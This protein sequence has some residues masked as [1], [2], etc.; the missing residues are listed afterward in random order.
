[1]TKEL[2]FQRNILPHLE[3]VINWKKIVFLEEETVSELT[4]IGLIKERE[5]TDRDIDSFIVCGEYNV[6]FHRYLYFISE[7]KKGDKIVYEYSDERAKE[8]K[9]DIIYI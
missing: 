9:S 2:F 8:K 7:I 4:D 6:R 3:D 5:A 1:M